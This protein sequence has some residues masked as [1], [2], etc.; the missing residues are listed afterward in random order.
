MDHYISTKDR[1]VLPKNGLIPVNSMV[2]LLIR[3]R[4]FEEQTACM[5][6]WF[7]RFIAFVANENHLLI[8]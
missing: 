8:N 2:C 4:M 1:K 6:V 3:F 5:C 7:F